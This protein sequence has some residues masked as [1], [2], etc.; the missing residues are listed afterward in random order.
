VAQL[1]NRVNEPVSLGLGQG[2]RGAALRQVVAAPSGGGDV[3]EG[4]SAM[5]QL[6]LFLLVRSVSR[7]GCTRFGSP[8]IFGVSAC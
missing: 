4:T 3:S 7:L 5:P 1:V 6:R 2:H 8:G